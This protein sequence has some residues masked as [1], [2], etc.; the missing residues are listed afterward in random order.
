MMEV[1]INDFKWEDDPDYFPNKDERSAS[2][3]PRFLRFRSVAHCSTIAISLARGR[4]KQRWGIQIA[5]DDEGCMVTKVSDNVLDLTVRGMN[6]GMLQKDDII[7]SITNENNVSVETP[8]ESNTS[9]HP[10]WF[11]E[12]VELFNCSNTLHM[13]VLRQNV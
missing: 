4:T 9:S 1:A 10:A 5:E 3:L 13:K 12:V 8:Q 6:L 11:S 7:L 2:F